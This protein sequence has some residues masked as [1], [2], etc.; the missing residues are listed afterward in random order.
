[1]DG[2]RLMSI[3]LIRISTFVGFWLAFSQVAVG[4]D[5]SAPVQ[6]Q[7]NSGMVAPTAPPAGNSSGIRDLSDRPI[8]ENRAATADK[9]SQAS[10]RATTGWVGSTMTALGVVLGLIAL[11]AWGVKKIMPGGALGNTSVIQVLHKTYLTPKQFLAVVKLGRRMMLIGVTNE[12]MNPLATID[13]P[14][15]V[16]WLTTDAKTA[17]AG[18]KNFHKAMG[19]ELS[20]YEQLDEPAEPPR[21]PDQAIMDQTRQRLRGLLQ[22]VKTLTTTLQRESADTR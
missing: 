13:D 9:R 19:Q 2:A 6:V 3:S 8:G 12:Q 17:G 22:K 15:E 5:S 21:V 10:H 4:Q 11:C 18:E 16:A 14:E 1:M 7:A 20:V